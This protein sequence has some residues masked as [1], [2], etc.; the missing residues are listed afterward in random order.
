ML[1]FKKINNFNPL[2]IISYLK[3]NKKE[4]LWVWICYQSIKG[5]SNL[6]FYLD[7]VMDLFKKI[8]QRH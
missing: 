1:K 7:T 4:F 5:S 2:R 3:S 6:K 8:T